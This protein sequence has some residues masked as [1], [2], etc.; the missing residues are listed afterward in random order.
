MSTLLRLAKQQL[1]IVDDDEPDT[2]LEQHIRAAS[3]YVQRYTGLDHIAVGAS[4][5]ITFKSQPAVGD[6]V[7]LAGIIFTA[8]GA[9][10]TAQQFEIGA[11]LAD[12]AQNFA[13]AW[14]AYFD[15]LTTWPDWFPIANFA[16]NVTTLTSGEAAAP[17]FSLATT[18]DAVTLSGAALTDASPGPVIQATLMLVAHLYQCRE[19]S[20]VG[21][22]SETVPFGVWD[23]LAPYREWSF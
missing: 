9:S 10:P 21:V 16:N 6:T 23:L 8:I 7:T 11:T 3:E 2:L 5:T 22:S 14:N 18:S 20:L 12:T 13:D 15:S 17:A 1:N 4:G 19:A